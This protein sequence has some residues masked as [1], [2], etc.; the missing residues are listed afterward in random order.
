MAAGCPRTVSFPPKEMIK[1]GEEMLEYVTKNQ[2]KMLHL[3]QWYCIE[4]MFTEKQWETFID[5]EEFIPYYEKALKLVG[6]NYLD[7]NSNVRDG[8]SQRWQRVYF[9]DLKKAEDLDAD[10]EV[11][12]K[13]SALKSETQAIE[14]EKLKVLEEVQRSKRLPK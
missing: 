12:R 3:S 6:V 13:A 9:K 1:L 4:K 8:I 7:K 5:R 2:K 10:A 14:Q 11:I